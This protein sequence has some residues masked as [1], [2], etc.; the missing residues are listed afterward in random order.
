MLGLMLAMGRFALALLA[1]D[2][3]LVLGGLGRRS[4]RFV[5]RNAAPQRRAQR[6]DLALQA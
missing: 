6:A 1:F 3:G 5:E 4:R 2:G